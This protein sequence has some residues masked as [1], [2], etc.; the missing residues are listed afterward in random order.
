VG[1]C[2]QGQQAWQGQWEGQE[3]WDQ[4]GKELFDFVQVWTEGIKPRVECEQ[5]G[6]TAGRAFYSGL[7]HQLFAAAN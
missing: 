3:L 6:R 5:T 2:G 4:A 1:G 7:G